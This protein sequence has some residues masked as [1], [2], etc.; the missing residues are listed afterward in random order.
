MVVI[1]DGSRTIKNR[2]V[3]LFRAQYEHILDG[4]HLKKKLKELMSMIAPNKD[5]KSQYVSELSTLLWCGNIE[6]AIGKLEKYQIKNQEKHQELLDYLKKNKPY[7]IDYAKRKE[8]GKTIG[9]GRMEKP[10]TVSWLEG[11]RKKQ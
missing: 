1:S 5:A 4:Y 6:E 2:S 3:E 11:K 7:I 8:V 9:S 10:W